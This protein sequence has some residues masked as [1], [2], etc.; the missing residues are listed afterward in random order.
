[1][2]TKPISRDRLKYW[3]EK[4]ELAQADYADEK[5]R[6]NWREKLYNGTHEI[7]PAPGAKNGAKDARHVQNIVAEMI[8]TQ[9]S[10]A[11]PMPKVQAIRPQDEILATKIENFLRNEV[12]DKLAE[13]I[14]EDRLKDGSSVQ[15]V[16]E[17]DGD[18]REFIQAV[19]S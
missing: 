2:K 14:L 13:L 1:M 7:K 3:Q 17:R 9:V 11:I 10:S 8:E 12:E 5:D 6:M 18:N 19:Y 4:F 15:F 16:L